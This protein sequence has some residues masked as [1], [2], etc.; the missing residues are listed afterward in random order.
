MTTKSI[1]YKR[2]KKHN[3]SQLNIQKLKK[4]YIKNKPTN[5]LKMKTQRKFTKKK[6]IIIKNIRNFH[7]KSTKKSLSKKKKNNFFKLFHKKKNITFYC[8]T[9]FFIFFNKNHF[10][11]QKR[12]KFYHLKINKKNRKQAILQL[13]YYFTSITFKL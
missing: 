11:I 1:K 4:L 10:V 2:P 8:S 6:K 12:K 13:S 3:A 5:P 7:M 9:C